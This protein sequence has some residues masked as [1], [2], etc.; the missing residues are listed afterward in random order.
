[1]NHEAR[2]LLLGRLTAEV[3]QE[4]LRLNANPIGERDTGRRTD[5]NRKVARWYER[6]EVI[7]RDLEANL[8]F[9][10]VSAPTAS[11]GNEGYRA[12][13]GRQEKQEKAV[14]NAWYA[15]YAEFSAEVAKLLKR[16]MGTQHPA[17]SVL[18]ALE[19]G[20]D[21]MKKSAEMGKDLLAHELSHV[22]QQGN[23]AVA[24]IEAAPQA[25]AVPPPG[26]MVSPVGVLM[27]ALSLLAALRNSLSDKR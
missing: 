21:H 20:L 5:L 17:R 24:M 19:N 9:R 15:P 25:P 27:I 12:R 7:R 16:A 4:A 10:Q 23:S 18:D 26:G 1:M 11:F 14:R 2:K 22:S 3:R 13:K 6:A 8:R